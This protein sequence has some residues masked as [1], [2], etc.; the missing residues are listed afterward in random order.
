MEIV[1]LQLGVRLTV[2]L[3][4]ELIVTVGAWVCAGVR[5][6]MTTMGV[7]VLGGELGEVLVVLLVGR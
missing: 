1:R 7:C 4:E 2:G 5:D 6:A 3:Q